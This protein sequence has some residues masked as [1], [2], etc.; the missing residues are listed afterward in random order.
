MVSK[1]TGSLLLVFDCFRVLF[2]LLNRMITKADYPRGYEDRDNTKSKAI[3]GVLLEKEL[4]VTYI[5]CP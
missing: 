1:G 5:I 4:E 2:S 3:K